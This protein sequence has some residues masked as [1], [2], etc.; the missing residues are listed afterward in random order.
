MGYIEIE[1]ESGRRR[2]EHTGIDGVVRIASERVEVVDG[3]DGP[4]VALRP[5]AGADATT[6]DEAVTAGETPESL[7]FGG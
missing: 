4:A 6:S 5:D 1:T 2:V 3:A 7:L